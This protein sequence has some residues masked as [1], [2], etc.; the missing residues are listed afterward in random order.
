M[1]VFA[2]RN[3]SVPLRFISGQRRDSKP[4]LFNF[5]LPPIFSAFQSFSAFFA[6]LRLEIASLVLL[7]VWMGTSSLAGTPIRFGG[8]PAELTLS[9]VSERTMRIQLSPLD[10]HGQPQPTPP[11]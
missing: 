9:E 8:A 4:A 11:S 7:L 3:K 1:K 5:F 2:R 10:E 6:S